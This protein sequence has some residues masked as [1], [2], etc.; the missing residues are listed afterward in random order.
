MAIQPQVDATI[1]IYTV[2][3]VEG[4]IRVHPQDGWCLRDLREPNI[5]RWW[6]Q[7]IKLVEQLMEHEGDPKDT[8][9]IA[10]LNDDAIVPPGWFDAVAT[11]M[12]DM[13]AAAGCSG[14]PYAN[15]IFHTHVGPV[16]LHTR[17]QGYAFILAGEKR[18]RANEDLSWYFS[19]DFIDWTARSKGGMVMIPGYNVNHLY[20]NGQMTPELQVANAES[21]A[22]FHAIWGVMPW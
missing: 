12:R 11:K 19:D 21:A 2:P 17:L 9:S 7:G 20:P 1:L 6:N 22:K 3:Y 8:W 18:I 5:S 15:A 13:R 14:S 10:I 16:P 4:E